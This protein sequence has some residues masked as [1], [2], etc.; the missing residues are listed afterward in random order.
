ML[1]VHQPVPMNVMQRH[2]LL[3]ILYLFLLLPARVTARQQLPPY[4]E[5][6]HITHYDD[7]SGLPSNDIT[8]FFEDAKGYYWFTTQFGLVRFDG[9][10][11]R[12]YYTGNM[13]T[14]T[15]NRLYSLNSDTGNMVYFGDESGGVHV[16]DSNG[17]IR[18]VPGAKARYNF[19]MSR[20]GFTLDLR[21]YLVN[22]A[23]S[24]RIMNEVKATKH[25][26]AMHEFYKS[27]NG[28]AW[29]VSGHDISYFKDGYFFPVDYYDEEE[30]RHFYIDNTLFAVDSIGR[31]SVYKAG[32]KT[33]LSLSLQ[34][35]LGTGKKAPD[36]RQLVFCSNKM[37]TF[38][39]YE[40]Q[41]L[42]LSFDGRTV[43]TRLLL[44]GLTLPLAKDIYYSK[45]YG[46]YILRTS[47]KGFYLIRNQ[48]F[49]V[50]SFTDKDGMENSFTASVEIRP[51]EVLTTN[52]VLFTPTAANRIYSNDLLIW[53]TILK[54]SKQQVWLMAGDTLL[55]LNSKLQE[56]KRWVVKHDTYLKSLL[57]DSKGTIW[58]CSNN[59]LARIDNGQ[60]KTLYADYLDYGRA[61]CMFLLNDSTIWL[62]TTEGLYAYHI[63]T[64]TITPEKDM[65]TNYVRHIY[66]AKDGSIWIGTYGQGFYTYRNGRFIPLPQDRKH[67]LATA[68]CFMEDDKGFFWIPTNKGLFQVAKQMLED[69]IGNR[70]LQVYYHY[71]D[72]HDGFGTNE[73]NGGSSP[74]GI[75]LQDGTF[76]LPSMKG[77]VWFHPSRVQPDLPLQDIFIDRV[78]S[79][80]QE[81]K[82]Q[83]AIR[84]EPG[85][86][87]ISFLLSSPFFGNR[88]NFFPEYRIPGV[89][90]DWTPVPADNNIVVNY[91]R[92]GT[93]TL[94]IRLRHGFDAQAYTSKSQQFTLAPFFYETREF[95]ILMILFVLGL[96]GWGVYVFIKWRTKNVR[97]RELILEKQVQQRTSEQ[98]VT[99][100]KLE[101]SVTDL[102]KSEESLHQSN[103]LKDKLTS[104]IL[105][106]I[107]SPLRFMNLLSNQL[108][109]ALSTGEN[110]PLTALT[111]ELKKST[112]QLDAFTREFLVW[113]NAQQNDFRVRN[114]HVYVKEMFEEAD[115]FFRNILTGNE[116][117]LE[118]SV[119]DDISM[120]TDKQLLRI[121]LHNIIDNAN[122]HTDG[123]LIR[124]SAYLETVDRVVIKVTD[125]GKGMRHSE[126][127]E[128]Q[129]RL[130][131][132]NNAFVTD[133]TGNLGYRI[134]RD[135]VN[136]LKGHIAVESVF[137]QGTT[138]TISF[139]VE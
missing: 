107:R 2:G 15:S 45:R 52:G 44:K 136:K 127:Q 22:A 48:P 58:Y 130:E 114:E 56:Q 34:S 10:D 38:L 59:G 106:D 67:S 74:V 87:K 42:A 80:T 68:H 103:L 139:P 102:K 135:F 77:L 11:F 14:L 30:R 137:K 83:G 31:I 100:Q 79:D 5:G 73:F 7:E 92:P 132:E 91:L 40:G 101:Q 129:D 60:M 1:I 111:A 131:N 27:S 93:Y 65:A 19:L 133:S 70:D 33:N 94:D 9:R 41:L 66:R 18:L 90:K 99:V 4:F 116:N 17:L 115:N 124:L 122:K 57:E 54:D 64:N 86:R 118:V 63:N 105:H 76:S 32:S 21:K 128:L 6:Y 23:D 123:G 51:M 50:H 120:W 96:I 95:L 125:T 134:M 113:L 37:G 49:A 39:Q 119:A 81:V 109:N 69:W 78:L 36:L 53:N 8:G 75:T 24:A 117:T 98:A 12:H 26:L 121:I 104:I 108:H 35:I 46:M 71:Y 25:Y 20:H 62:G 28:H 3:T 61:Q 43:Q 29:F 47:T 138:V 110:Q 126:L 55:C 13:P 85:T 89:D 112:D 82:Y 16:I 97:E 88:D 84:F 72:R